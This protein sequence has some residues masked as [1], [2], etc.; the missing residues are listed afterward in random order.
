MLRC[1]HCSST[2]TLANLRSKRILR[3]RTCEACGGQYFEGGTTVALAVVGAGCSLAPCFASR[4][5]FPAWL[6]L[7]VAGGF[8]SLAILYT[9]YNQPRK[10]SELGTAFVQG[11]LAAIASGTIVMVARKSIAL[12]L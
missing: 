12:A 6:P 8:A 1:P 9:Q 4:E 2:V 3:P 11:I 10:A 7:V 5:H